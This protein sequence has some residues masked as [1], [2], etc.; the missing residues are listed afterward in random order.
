MIYFQKT[1]ASTLILCIMSYKNIKKNISFYVIY[2]IYIVGW[3]FTVMYYFR[4]KSNLD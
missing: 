1:P 2:C 4:G 3:A